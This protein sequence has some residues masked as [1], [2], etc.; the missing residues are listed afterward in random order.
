M[1]RLVSVSLFAGAL[2]AA[3]PVAAQDQTP[4]QP[5]PDQSTP[6][7]AAPAQSN[8]AQSTPPQVAP[9]EST[10][11]QPAPDQ[12]APQQPQGEAAP[13]GG[14]IGN[15]FCSKDLQPMLVQRETLAKSLQAINK[16]PR[17]KTFQQAQKTFNDFCGGLS[18]YIAN[19]KKL[20]NYM[21]SNKDF[22]SISDQNIEQMTRDMTQTQTTRAKICSHPPRQQAAPAPKGGGGQ[23]IPKPPVNLQLQ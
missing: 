21:S 10:P 5:V 12:S 8:P 7:Q 3:T 17:P 14:T 15:Q 9:V 13:Q 1:L 19:D 2:L 22:C 23:A 6:Q 4:Q 11:Q 20:L 16:R 18:A